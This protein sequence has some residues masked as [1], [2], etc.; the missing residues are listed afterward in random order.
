M[1]GCKIKAKEIKRLPL[2]GKAES[3]LLLL[4]AVEVRWGWAW[5]PVPFRSS[6]PTL[7]P[8]PGPAEKPCPGMLQPGLPSPLHGLGHSF[9]FWVGVGS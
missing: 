8:S 4:G 6:S 3:A 7:N 2:A 1:L 5:S 9:L